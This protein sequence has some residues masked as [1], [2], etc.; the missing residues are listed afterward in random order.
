M[1]EAEPK[2]AR[3]E[4]ERRQI[5]V[6]F[7]DMVGYTPLAERLGEEA[8]YQLIRPITEQMMQAVENNRG[9]VHD[10]TGD[11]L[12]AVFGMPV[13]QEDAPQ[14]ACQTALD[15]VERIEGFAD[16]YESSHGV[17]PQIR[18][19]I[20]TGPAV[21]GRIGTDHRM[22]FR[23]VG[24]T[25]NLVS[26]LESSA[27]PGQILISATMRELVAGQAQTRFAG[28]R[29]LKGKT[30]PQEVYS[31][32]G[33][34]PGIS[35]FEAR[36]S[37]G[38]TPLVG[39]NDELDKLKAIWAT[40]VSGSVRL[41]HIC[42]EPGIGK[43]RLLHEFRERTNGTQPVFLQ[44]HCT[45]D[46]GTTPFL[47]F[48]DMLRRSFGIGTND[49]NSVLTERLLERFNILNL[50][51]ERHIP[52]LANLVG[53]DTGNTLDKVDA[54]VIGIRTRETLQSACIDR[55]LE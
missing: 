53:A 48:V 52:Y 1:S 22:E 2:S 25:V 54:E 5:T 34:R 49:E 44:G 26:R 36:A 28:R 19:G 16:E 39:R 55:Y 23:A 18:I 9:T 14:R 33:L 11:G 32:E 40:V 13:A 42:G 37:G 46:G 47:P 15:I 6:L 4:A 17:H 24:D 7:V 51:A 21:V 3:P 27:E 29:V 43:S 12:M 50:P 10:L 30:E 31:L 35:R 45:S 20:H 41:V 38:L 8:L